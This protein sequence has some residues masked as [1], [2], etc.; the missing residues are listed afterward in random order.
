MRLCYI[1]MQV[2]KLSTSECS[3]INSDHLQTRS[4]YSSGINLLQ[5]TSMGCSDSR[6]K[7][8]YKNDKINLYSTK[9]S[10]S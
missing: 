5:R 3:I 8:N 4:G 6:K 9:T 2:I 1:F 10:Q 7:G